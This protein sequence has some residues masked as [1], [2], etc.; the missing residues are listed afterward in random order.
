MQHPP[1]FL[2]C[3]ERSGSNLISRIV[4]AH[5]AFYAPPPFHFGQNVL[6]NLHQTLAGGTQS[7]A[8][9]RMC[10]RIPK[11][12]EKLLGTKKEAQ[13]A[14]AWLSAQDKIDPHRLTRFLYID[15]TP[16][17]A[18]KRV[19]IK[20]NNLHKLLFFILECFPDAKF[21]FQVRDPRDY[22]ASAAALREGTKNKFGTTKNALRIWKEDQLGGLHA[23]GVLG[24]ERVFLHRYEDLL[25]DAEAV[26]R[27]LCLFLDQ[28]FEPEMLDFHSTEEATT[29]AGSNRQRQNVAKPLMTTNFAKF[30]HA[31][32]AQQIRLVEKRLGRLMHQFGYP[33]DKMK[34]TSKGRIVPRSS[35]GDKG[36]YQ[37]R[38][39]LSPLD[40]GP[41]DT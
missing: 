17:A 32:P 38:P 8:W 29:L 40:Y 31:L 35:P 34:I 7:V 3:S 39:L 18:G 13:A 30:R 22:F 27:R 23:L 6:L 41:P 5:S 2:I 26:L 21:I 33:L 4:G 11:R 16:A 37:A 28:S 24:P 1:V 20:E 10:N 36:G 14:A 15:A 9:Q 19:F 12:L 25:I